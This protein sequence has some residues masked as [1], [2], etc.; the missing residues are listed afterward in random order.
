MVVDSNPTLPGEHQ[1]RSGAWRRH[2]WL[3]VGAILLSL[4]VGSLVVVDRMAVGFAESV[5]SEQA[6]REIARQDITSAKP[7]IDF[8]GFPFLT[9][10][11]SGRYD[12]ITIVVRDAH[13]PVNGETVN[14]PKLTIRARGVAASLDT[15]R[16]GQGTV[17]ADSV[18]GVAVIGYDTVTEFIS[19]DQLE[20]TERDGQLT[21]TAPLDVLGETMTATGTARITVEDGKLRVGFDDLTVDGLPNNPLARKVVNDYARK[22]SVD[23]PLP[24]LPYDLQLRAVRALPTG[25][26]VTAEARNVAL[27]ALS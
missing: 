12:S 27:N 16:N 18:Q 4:L 17:M 6:A 14:L 19:Q 23:V 25:L 21:V 15:L 5:I 8:D 26:E 1:E 2:R 22:I 7:E 3:I 20:L 9:Q 11:V 10:V 13:G 24:A